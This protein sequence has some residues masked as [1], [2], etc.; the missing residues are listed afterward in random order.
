MMKTTEKIDNNCEH[1]AYFLKHYYNI[2]GTFI[3]APGC[4]N[5]IHYELTNAERKK[6]LKNTVKCELWEP[7][8]KQI[9]QRRQNI[10]D[11]ICKMEKA[12]RD[13]AQILKEDNKSG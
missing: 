8:Q 3:S 6:R 5:C 7:E 13:I 2:R 11:T 1:C 12:L 9:E 10:E 4:K